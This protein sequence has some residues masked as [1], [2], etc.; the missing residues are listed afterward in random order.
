L[1]AVTNVAPRLTIAFAAAVKRHR[2]RRGVSQETLAEAAAVHRTYVGLIERGARTP[3][4]DVAERI[5]K[6][7]GLSLSALIKEAEREL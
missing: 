6:A 4:I 2:K 3:T 1:V 5:A 7:L